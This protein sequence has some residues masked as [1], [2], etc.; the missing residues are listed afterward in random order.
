MGAL[1]LLLDVMGEGKGV[2][3]GTDTHLTPCRV[4]TLG[5]VRFQLSVH[6]AVCFFVESDLK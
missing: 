1:S 3:T 5:V 6:L 2:P 4:K